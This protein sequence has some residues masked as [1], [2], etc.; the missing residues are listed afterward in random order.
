MT[1]T[2]EILRALQRN[3]QA[4]GMVVRRNAQ[5]DD[6][7]EEIAA[8]E[9]G[10]IGAALILRDGQG[11]LVEQY[12]GS[13]SGD[14]EVA[15]R[16]EVEWIVAG[17]E[18]DEIE[19]AFDAGLVQIAAIVRSDPNLGGLV[20][21]CRIVNPPERGFDELGAKIAKSALIEIEAQFHSPDP[22]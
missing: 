13:G 7:L 12:L 15:H 17:R 19:R 1:R 4:A 5:L 11:V 22:F 18:G 9:A 6:V 21:A 20:L 3:L 10:K 16:A 2:E 14:F 8:G